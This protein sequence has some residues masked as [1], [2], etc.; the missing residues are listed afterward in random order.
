M[1][2]DVLDATIGACGMATP[3]P[4]AALAPWSLAMPP[5]AAVVTVDAAA[6][7]A[8]GA[9]SGNVSDLGNV[10]IAQIYHIVFHRQPVYMAEACIGVFGR[11]TRGLAGSPGR[12]A[13]W[14]ASGGGGRSLVARAS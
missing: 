14:V 2:A 7:P 12:P 6:L 3:R 10:I 13:A 9:F 4:A 1:T 8:D 5:A 11:S